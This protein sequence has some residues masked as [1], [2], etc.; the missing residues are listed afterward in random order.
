MRACV[1]LIQ[2]LLQNEFII[3]IIIL[4]KSGKNQIFNNPFNFPTAAID[5]NL[6]MAIYRLAWTKIC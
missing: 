4:C 6:A 3:E 1:A 5:W 2:Q